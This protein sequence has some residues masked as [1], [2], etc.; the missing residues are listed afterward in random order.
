MNDE[1]LRSALRELP[2]PAPRAGF[3]TRVLAR[4]ERSPRRRQARTLP[5]WVTAA[6]AVTLLA[7]G[8]WG[9]AAGVQAVQQQRRRAA[10]QQESAALARELAALRAEVAKPAPMLYLGGTEQVD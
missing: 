8:L 10:L 5:A 1:R 6:A 2:A 9:T 4:L 3:T 7:G